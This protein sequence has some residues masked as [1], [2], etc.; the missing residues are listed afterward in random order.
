MCSS[1]RVQHQHPKAHFISCRAFYKCDIC[2]EQRLVPVT[3][4]HLEQRLCA[5]SV[6][7]YLLEYVR[8]AWKLPLPDP[9]VAVAPCGD[10]SCPQW[11]AY[12]SYNSRPRPLPPAIVYLRAHKTLAAEARSY[13]LDPFSF[14]S[15]DSFMEAFASAR[16]EAHLQGGDRLGPER[17]YDLLPIELWDIVVR[18]LDTDDLVS[19]GQTCYRLHQLVQPTIASISHILLDTPAPPA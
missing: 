5:P 11:L 12:H 15:I 8:S 1:S 4:A 3:H 6:G 9:S 13:H 14:D 18:F 7:N 19:V 2:A 10:T 17:C 16:K